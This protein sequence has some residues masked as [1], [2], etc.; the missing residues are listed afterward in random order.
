[1]AQKVGIEVENLLHEFYN[2]QDKYE[3]FKQFGATR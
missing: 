1:M 3:I 2:V